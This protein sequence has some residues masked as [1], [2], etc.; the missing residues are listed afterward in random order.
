ME[1]LS[2]DNMN[3]LGHGPINY[4][5]HDVM[6]T[7]VLCH[8][9]GEKTVIISAVFAL[10]LTIRQF[11]KCRKCDTYFSTNSFVSTFQSIVFEITMIHWV[12]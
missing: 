4:F 12:K 8:D 11:F 2:H 5:G 10:F 7:T 1:G 9:I 3:C 6:D